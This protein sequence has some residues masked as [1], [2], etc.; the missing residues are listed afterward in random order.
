M[1]VTWH[2][3]AKDCRVLAKHQK[4]IISATSPLPP[5]KK[6]KNKQ[7]TNKKRLKLP[8]IPKQLFPFLFLNLSSKTFHSPNIAPPQPTIFTTFEGQNV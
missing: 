5:Q 8:K 7:K 6:K 1:H 2:Q 4:V 3:A